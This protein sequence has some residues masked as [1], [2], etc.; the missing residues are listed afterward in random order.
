MNM[1]K[2]RKL[3]TVLMALVMVMTIIRPVTA[4][5]AAKPKLNKTKVTLTITAKK[6]NPAVKLKAKNAKG[7]VKWSTS[8][9][10]V[11]TVKNGKVAA[12][13]AGKATI[14]CKVNKKKLTCKVTVKD[15]RTNK[16]NAKGEL[17]VEIKHSENMAL[18]YFKGIEFADNR[19]VVTYN[20]R[21]VTKKADCE[22]IED[23][24]TSYLLMDGVITKSRTDGLIWNDTYTLKVTYQGM[25]KSMKVKVVTEKHNYYECY[26]GA[27][28]YDSDNCDE[29]TKKIL[30]EAQKNGT[31]DAALEMH[32]G[33]YNIPCGITKVIV[34]K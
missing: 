18:P 23:A 5:A 21:D 14:T 30:D 13:S 26:C 28:F 7:K 15:K 24:V 27:Q 20:G 10:K 34:V 12:K 25:E 17:K 3:F 22:L 32:G 11:A 31:L 8:N 4:D 9:K 1:K 33:E 29:H 19:V 16:N 2:T 6:K